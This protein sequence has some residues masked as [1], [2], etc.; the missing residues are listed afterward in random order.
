MLFKKKPSSPIDAIIVG[1]GNPEAKY[2]TTRH[3]VGF[4]AVDYVANKLGASYDYCKLVAYRQ[5][6]AV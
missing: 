5:R 4:N 2:T 1:L 3:N 6:K